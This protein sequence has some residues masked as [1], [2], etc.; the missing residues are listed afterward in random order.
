MKRIIVNCCLVLALVGLGWYCYLS[1]KA[2]IVMLENLPFELHGEKRPGIEAVNVII[3]DHEPV[4]LL[5]GDQIPTEAS[6]RDKVLQ[7]DILDENN[8]V[9]ESKRIPF[10]LRD[11][12]DQPKIN[13]AEAFMTQETSVEE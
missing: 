13:V 8:K 4:L 3:G 2:Y 11:L 9:I 7:I 6:R 5:E 12:G 1:G 10:S